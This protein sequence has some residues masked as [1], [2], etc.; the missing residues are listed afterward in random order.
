MFDVTLMTCIMGCV[1]YRNSLQMFRNSRVLEIG[2]F[3]KT[4]V[5]VSILNAAMD[6][7]AWT[8]HSVKGIATVRLQVH[9][10][11]ATKDLESAVSP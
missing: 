3:C 8:L 7:L 9:V 10:V 2:N 11:Q 6:S 5:N 1:Q 4:F